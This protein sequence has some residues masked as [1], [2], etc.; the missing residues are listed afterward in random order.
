MKFVGSAQNPV[1]T[2]KPICVNVYRSCVPLLS[3]EWAFTY[4]CSK[5]TGK[6]GVPCIKQPRWQTDRSPPSGVEI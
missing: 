6:G 4:G 2:N 5:A 3:V 1:F